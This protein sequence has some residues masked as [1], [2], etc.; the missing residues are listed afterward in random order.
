MNEKIRTIP[1]TGNEEAIKRLEAIIEGL[2]DDRIMITR[3][4]ENADLGF[5]PRTYQSDTRELNLEYVR[6]K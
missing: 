5:E 2:K 6:I 4:R 1:P 3:I